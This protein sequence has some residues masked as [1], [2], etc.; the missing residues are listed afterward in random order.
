M[1]QNVFV[2]YEPVDGLFTNVFTNESE[3]EKWV[4]SDKMGSDV[5]GPFTLPVEQE[6]PFDVV[7][8]A[9]STPL[10]LTD[11]YVESDIPDSVDSKSLY[12]PY[13]VYTSV[14]EFMD[15]L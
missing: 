8:E 1:P 7:L 10:Q 12:G 15:S 5:L 2:T 3:A 13:T 6:T 14:E 11:V 4:E 9:H